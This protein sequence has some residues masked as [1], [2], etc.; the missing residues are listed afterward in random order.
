MSLLPVNKTYHLENIAQYT[1]IKKTVNCL[2]PT[3]NS[4]TAMKLININLLR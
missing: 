1:K 3:Q 4:K 2:K